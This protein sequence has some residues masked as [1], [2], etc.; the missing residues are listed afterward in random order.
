MRGLLVR[1]FF[2]KYCWKLVYIKN[3]SIF[4]KVFVFMPFKITVN[5]TV[6]SRLEE[7]PV[8]KSL[9]SEKENL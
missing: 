2:H 1:I 6:W 7:K 3:Y 5:L 8:I 9:M 4:A